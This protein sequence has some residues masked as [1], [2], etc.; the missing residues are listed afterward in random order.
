MTEK[1]KESISN[2]IQ[3]IEKKIGVLRQFKNNTTE[4]TINTLH[5]TKE[6]LEK[7]LKDEENRKSF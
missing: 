4:Q 6:S 5:K 1:E 2:V 7:V 3:I